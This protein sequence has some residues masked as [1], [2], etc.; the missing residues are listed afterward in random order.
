ME[1][2]RDLQ[3]IDNIVKA[4]MISDVELIEL[5]MILHG[6]VMLHAVDGGLDP[7]AVVS[8][9]QARLLAVHHFERR[10]VDF[11]QRNT[12]VQIVWI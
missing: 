9:V 2:T 3:I 11:V 12:F 8:F 5:V 6:H 7:E 4:P 1:E 10:V